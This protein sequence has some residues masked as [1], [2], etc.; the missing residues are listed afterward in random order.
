MRKIHTFLWGFVCLLLLQSPAMADTKSSVSRPSDDTNIIIRSEETI[1][2]VNSLKS[3]TTR[4]KVSITILNNNG[5]H[6]AKQYV[7]YDKLSKVGYIKGVS[8]DRSGNKIKTLKNKDVTDVSAIS[9]FSLYEDNRV[10]IADLTHTVYPY[11]VEF[12][13]EVTFENLLFYPIFH[14][15]DEERLT[16]EK[17]SFEVQMPL[18][19]KLRYLE[20][21]VPQ[22]AKKTA[23]ATHEVYTWQVQNLKPVETEPF[24]PGLEELVPIVRTAPT[25]F[26]V[27]GYKGNMESWKSYGLWIDQLNKGRDVLPEAT[28]QKL[29]EL[30]SKAKTQEEKVRIVYDYLQGKTR[31][32]SIQLGIGGWQPFE[33]SFV[34]SKG[35][36]DCKALTNY[37]QAMLKAV[38][39]NSYQALIRAGDGEPDIRTNFPSSQFNHVVLSVPMAKDTLWLE[40]TSQTEAA[41]YAGSSTGGRH[42]LLITPE[43]GKLVKTPNYKATDNAQIRQIKVTLD[44]KGSGSASVTTRYT[45]LQQES[46]ANAVQNMQPD[47]QRKWLYQQVKIPAFEIEKYAFVQQK[48]KLPAVTE[49][50]ELSLRQCATI[51]GKRMFVSPNLMSKW[52]YV[53]NQKEKR[54]TDVVRRMAFLDVDTVEFQLPAGYAVEYLP[55]EVVHKSV[56]GEYKASVKVDGQ[57]VVYLRSMQ[58]GKGRYSPESYTQ[59][60]TFLNN[61]IKSDSE[62]VVFVK[63][64]P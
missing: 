63:N 40:C 43:G 54:L 16:V 18:G 14:P 23:T 52:T 12:E 9:D 50:L 2:T 29:V 51:S 42:A 19:M 33:A 41:G 13:Y 57:R 56:F 61:V 25:D 24:G 7:H 10:K 49:Q 44:E 22:P 3:G 26:E 45:G 64:I 20:S 39:I 30:T 31:Y 38:G 62:K 46:H 15:Q 21:N 37:T 11:T 4:Y 27:E 36:G 28:K 17:A 5:N 32:V 59:L 60:V 55:Q 34:D 58:M 53:P 47:E 1:F 48:D 35:Y 8:Y 6:R